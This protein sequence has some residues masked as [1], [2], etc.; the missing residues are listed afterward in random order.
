MHRCFASLKHLSQSL[1]SRRL[2]LR[3]MS[4]APAAA[5]FANS[6]LKLDNL[7]KHL[8]SQLGVKEPF[9]VKA[10]LSTNGK[11]AAPASAPVAAAAPAA[12]QKPAAAAAA[13]GGAAAAAAGGAPAQDATSKPKKEKADKPAA[14]PKESKPPVTTPYRAPPFHLTIALPAGRCRPRH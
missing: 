2:S 3:N 13:A 12:P 4:A 6:C 11:P 5:P 1:L 8:E 10:A 7:I 14:P 9:D